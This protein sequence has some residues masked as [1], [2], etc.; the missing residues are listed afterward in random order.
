MHGAGRVTGPA[1][2]PPAARVLIV[3][4][5]PLVRRGLMEM[6]RSQPGVEVCG[7]AA[8]AAS[9]W[10]ELERTRPQLVMLDLSIPGSDGLELLKCIRARYPAIR[11]LVV[12]MH[13]EHTYAER[14]LR[15]GALGYVH[16]HEPPETIIHATH[17]V[18]AGRRYVSREVEERLLARLNGSAPGVERPARDALSDRELEVLA[19][20]G[21]G[22]T[23]SQIADEL[24]L[25]RKTV[26]SHREHLKQK[27]RLRNAAELVRY[28]VEARMAEER[29]GRKA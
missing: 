14:A 17:E 19:M 28:A 18:L 25:S 7:E 26:Q 2:P 21:E 29:G 24:H 3:D 8:D 16:K 27:L 11:I 10:R 6:L 12:S 5:H 23:T 13:E 20:L 22:K 15:A 4:D 1:T 9:T